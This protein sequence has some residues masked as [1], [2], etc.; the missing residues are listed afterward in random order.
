MTTTSKN[1]PIHQLSVERQCELIL[2]TYVRAYPTATDETRSI[3]KNAIEENTVIADKP[4]YKLL[5]TC[6][7]AAAVLEDYPLDFAIMVLIR[8]YAFY[9]RFC[10]ENGSTEACLLDENQV[11]VRS[12]EQQVEAYM[13]DFS[14]RVYT[15]LGADWAPDTV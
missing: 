1:V 12:T 4:I 11:A 5:P 6:F 8:F 3:L 15:I 14:E 13:I 7:H 9:R 10:L 2:F